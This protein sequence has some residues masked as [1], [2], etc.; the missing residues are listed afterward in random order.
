M[1][2]TRSQ[3]KKEKE[4]LVEVMES[5]ECVDCKLDDVNGPDLGVGD[6]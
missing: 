2:K 6:V 5:F 3:S 1:R 4:N